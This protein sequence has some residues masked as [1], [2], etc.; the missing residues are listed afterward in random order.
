MGKKFISLLACSIRTVYNGVLD[1]EDIAVMA[2]I[3]QNAITKLTATISVHFCFMS[4]LPPPLH[5]VYFLRNIYK[6]FDLSY[7][8]ELVL[9]IPLT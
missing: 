4:M 1:G 5:F 6:V 9:K 3:A 8:F 7:F 2:V